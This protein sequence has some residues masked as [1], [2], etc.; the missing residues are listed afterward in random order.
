MLTFVLRRLLVAIPVLF[1]ASVLIFVFVRLSPGDPVELLLPPEARGAGSEQY[2]ER[3][4]EEFGLDRPLP[5]QYLA[6]AGEMLQGNLGFSYVSSRPVLDMLL[7]R[8]GPT[9]TLMGTALVMSLLVAVP[10]GVLAA[11]KRGG[12][13]DRITSVAGL[14]AVSVPSFF[15]ALMLIKI[16]ALDLRLVPSAGMASTTSGSGGGLLDTLRHLILPAGTLALVLAGP[17]IRY[18]RQA[19]ADTLSQDFMQTARAMGIRSRR[20][21]F[22]LALRNALVPLTIVV[23]LELPMVIGGTVIIET[24]FAWP[25]M[26]RLLMTSITN[27]DYP[28][29]LGFTAIAG[30]AV[31]LS[32]L[33]ADV[34]VAVLDP[35]T[36]RA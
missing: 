35:R 15:L 19:M 5:V 9:A 27:L 26:G 1:L 22:V 12:A 13:V 30:V 29:I 25:G 23:F 17:H 3:L 10:L 4:R 14:T 7:E 18:I 6:W 16:F 28:V 33:V 2:R 34:L 21:Y 32:N 8:L 31:L 20:K 11:L 24:I 36:R